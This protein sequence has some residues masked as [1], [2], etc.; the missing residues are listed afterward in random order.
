V[1]GRREASD[2]AGEL[3]RMVKSESPFPHDEVVATVDRLL[4]L[5]LAED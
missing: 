5:L 4:Q 2:A 3:E 1:F